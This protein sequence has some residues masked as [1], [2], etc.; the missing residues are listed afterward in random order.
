MPATSLGNVAAPPQSH[1]S[2]APPVLSPVCFCRKLE[3]PPQRREGRYK[4][5]SGLGER[6]MCS[7]IFFFFSKKLTKLTISLS[8]HR[9]SPASCKSLMFR[10]VEGMTS[11]PPSL[12]CLFSFLFFPLVEDHCSDMGGTRGGKEVAPAGSPRSAP[13]PRKEAGL[14]GGQRSKS[15]SLPA[16]AGRRC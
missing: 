7:S 8:L 1:I 4:L 16:K 11:L 2:N 3:R 9:P 5:D 12:L 6:P 14:S 10:Q 15:P 13:S